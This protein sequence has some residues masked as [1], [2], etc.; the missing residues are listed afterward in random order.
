MLKSIL[1]FH[2]PPDVGS[3]IADIACFAD[4]GEIRMDAPMHWQEGGKHKGPS[5]RAGIKAMGLP[6]PPTI[7]RGCHV[8]SSASATKLK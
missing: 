6:R 1:Q 8:L 5:G 2:S 7:A 3:D 4:Q